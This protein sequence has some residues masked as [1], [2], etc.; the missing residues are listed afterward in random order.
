MTRKMKDSGIEWIGEIP[1]D[2]EIA[3]LKRF[4][5][6]NS[7]DFLDKNKF[8]ENGNVD[9]L[10][11]N[12]KI[13]EYN[14][15][16]LNKKVIVTGRVGTIG[17]LYIRENVWITDNVLSID[18]I[19]GNIEFFYYYMHILNFEKMS[20]TTAQP[21]ITASKLSNVNIV[22][23][24]IV[25]QEK[26]SKYLDIKTKQIEAI[27]NT[28]N[29]EIENLENYKK[30]LITEAVTKGLDKNVPMK[31]SDI[32]YIGNIPKNWEIKKVKYLIFER[33]DRSKDGEGELL[34]VSQYKG[35]IPSSENTFRVAQSRTLVGYKIVKINDLVFNKLNPELARFSVSNYNGLTSPDYAVYIVNRKFIHEKFLEFVLTTKRYAI[36]YGRVT[37]GVG[38]GFKRL[39]T[40]Q[41]GRFSVAFPNIKE[42]NEIVEY[43]KRITKLIDDSIAIKEKQ[44][45]TLEDY[46]K[47][48][49]YEY[50]TGKKEV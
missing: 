39:Y 13:G 23:P 25:E 20:Y 14:K 18:V 7:G 28:I 41:L 49:I 26:I 6:I 38:E 3:K 34:S 17:T 22:I 11:A 31:D 44:L 10:G 47:S 30:S 42:Q 5:Y 4:T 8:V 12:G 35:V 1:K 43:L 46:K 19:K 36:E 33:N 9:V 48:L 45:K 50:V 15:S 27:G 37:L 24:S 32:E 16:N 21:L 29:K 2:W 40:S